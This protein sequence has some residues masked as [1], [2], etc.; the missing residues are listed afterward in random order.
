V[1]DDKQ[2]VLRFQEKPVGDVWQINGGFFVLSP[3]VLKRIVDASTVWEEGPLTGL[4]ADGELVAFG[5]DGFWQP[6]GHAA[7]TRTFSRSSGARGR[8]PWKVWG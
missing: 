1:L 8:A 7:V 5:H 4:A 3:R 2:R 6:N